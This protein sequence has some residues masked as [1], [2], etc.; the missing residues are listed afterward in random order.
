MNRAVVQAEIDNTAYDPGTPTDLVLGGE[1]FTSLTD[2]I[3]GIVEQ[4]RPPRVW[5]IA[6]GISSVATVSFSL[7]TGTTPRA[8]SRKSV[9]WALR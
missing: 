5:Y 2:K 8:S 7:T 3:C 9:R 1:T 4:P 6:M